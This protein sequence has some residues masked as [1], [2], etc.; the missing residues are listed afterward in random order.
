MHDDRERPSQS[1]LMMRVA[2]RPACKGSLPIVVCI[3]RR[4]PRDQPLS[5]P[6]TTYLGRIYTAW[7]LTEP[8]RISYNHRQ[9]TEVRRPHEWSRERALREVAPD[10]HAYI[11]T[12][13]PRLDRYLNRTQRISDVSAQPGIVPIR[14]G[15]HMII[16]STSAEVTG[17]RDRCPRREDAE[18][19]HR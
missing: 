17:L 15:Y 14:S 1:P 13:S 7:D 19:G 9:H 8:I 18:R 16:A 6:Y 10:H 3:S 11:T 12:A 5:E 2:K 4:L